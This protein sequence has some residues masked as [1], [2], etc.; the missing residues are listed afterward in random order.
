M[1]FCGSWDQKKNLK[2]EDL[3]DDRVTKNL[4]VDLV[5]IPAV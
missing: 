3:F 2:F 4:K 5:S 1:E